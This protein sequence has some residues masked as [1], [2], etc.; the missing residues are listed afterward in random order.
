MAKISDWLK[1]ENF[2]KAQVLIPAIGAIAGGLA[3]WAVS[4]Y[5]LPKSVPTPSQVVI[6]VENKANA[7]GLLKNQTLNNKYFYEQ[8]TPIKKK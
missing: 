7:V 4:T 6:I 1:I 2:L 3:W 5:I 8:K